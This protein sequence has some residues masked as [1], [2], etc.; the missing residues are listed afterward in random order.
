M[1]G[2][3]LCEQVHCVICGNEQ[4]NRRTYF[5][6]PKSPERKKKWL[7]ILKIEDKRLKS[8]SRVCD[9]HFDNS[10]LSRTRLIKGAIPTLKPT[11][12]TPVHNYCAPSL[13]KILPKTR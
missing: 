13:V 8:R 9:K 3:K 5:A 4:E 7:N 1:S 11:K 6:F 2:K 10:Q 12:I